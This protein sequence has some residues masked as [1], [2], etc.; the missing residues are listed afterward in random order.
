VGLGRFCSSKRRMASDRVEPGECLA[1]QASSAASWC[2]KSVRWI[3]VGL[4]RGRPLD[5]FSVRDIDLAWRSVYEAQLSP[6]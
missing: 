2:G 6:A 1:I 4:V 3:E 5:F